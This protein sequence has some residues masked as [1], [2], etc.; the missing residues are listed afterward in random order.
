MAPTNA[1]TGPTS[2]DGRQA[3]PVTVTGIKPTGR[4]HLGN[5]IGS[6]RPALD[7]VPE[8]CAYYFIA[9]YHALTTFHDPG[10]LNRRIAEVAATWLA[11]GLNPE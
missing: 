2:M 10:T 8:N 9:D 4:I 7:L 5:Y 3:K 11:V 1:D 6:I